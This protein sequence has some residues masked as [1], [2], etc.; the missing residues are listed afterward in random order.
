MHLPHASAGTSPLAR[1]LSVAP[2]ERRSISVRALPTFDEVYERHLRFVWRVLRALGLPEPQV[3][4]MVQDVF[5]VVHR[6]LTEF[7][8]RS[9]IRTWLFQIARW[10]VANERRRQRARPSLDAL[11][12][13]VADR[14]DGPFDT[15][16]RSQAMERLEWILAQMDEEKR[17][18]FLLM[19]I[20]EMKAAEVAELLEINVNTAYSRLRL[21]REQFKG[22][23]SQCT[24]ASEGSAP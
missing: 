8:G 20:E 1:E 7:E 2:P 3:E 24:K 10:L 14:A 11:D 19:D 23:L 13:E 21:A 17:I 16:A 9:D 18:V 6:R 15:L 12:D 5:V 4:D 22:L